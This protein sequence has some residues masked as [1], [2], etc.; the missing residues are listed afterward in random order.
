MGNGAVTPPI[1]P[2]EGIKNSKRKA[3]LMSLLDALH[4]LSRDGELSPDGELLMLT[5][6]IGRLE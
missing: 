3:T 2:P 1:H 6:L 4:E 5:A